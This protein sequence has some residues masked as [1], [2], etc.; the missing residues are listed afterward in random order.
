MARHGASASEVCNF[1]PQRHAAVHDGDESSDSYRVSHQA[2]G[3]GSLYNETFE[4]GYYAA[5]WQE[6]ERPL[7]EDI[8]RPFGGPNRKCLDFAC[9]TGRIAGVA[10]EF[11]QQVV[12]VDVSPAMIQCASVPKNVSLRIVDIT[13]DDIPETFDVATAF[14]FFLNAEDALRR[15]ALL[16]IRRHLRDGGHLVCN[17]H[18]NAA[19]PAGLIYRRGKALFGERAQNT[20]GLEAFCA[21]LRD[22]GFVVEEV[23]YYGYL[24]RLGPLLNGMCQ[25][26]V[27]PAERLC[28]ALAV[29]GRFAQNFV[30]IA[31]RQ[32]RESSPSAADGFAARKNV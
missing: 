13:N 11:F 21:Y 22:A 15:D 27:A 24:P 18:M 16:G 29:P 6:I 25:R 2:P 14:R 32:G 10:A 28:R 12:G 3:Y 31:R 30:V 17:I 5:L 1:G 23:R 7:I 9:G 4:G 19:S 20:L 8:L 26:L